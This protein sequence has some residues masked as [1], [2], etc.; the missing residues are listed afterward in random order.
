EGFWGEDGES[1]Q[2]GNHRSLPPIWRLF[3]RDVGSGGF[4]LSQGGYRLL[5][6]VIRHVGSLLDLGDLLVYGQGSG[7]LA[8]GLVGAFTADEEAANDQGEGEA[9]YHAGGFIPSM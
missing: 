7:A 9:G 5:F 2:C 1:K 6:D 3:A 8:A 4:L